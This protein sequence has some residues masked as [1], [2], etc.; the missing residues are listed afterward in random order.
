M[1]PP[2]TVP[3][4]LRSLLWPIAGL[5]LALLP[6]AW[7]TGPALAPPANAVPAKSAG[8]TDAEPQGLLRLGETLTKRGDYA[9]AEIAYWQILHR[10]D[11]SL[12]Q[13]KT[14]LLGLAHAHRRANE[15][16][17]AV[18]IY[19]KYLK[20]YPE[21]VRVPD[22]LLDLGRTLR[23]MGVYKMAISCFYSVIN[24]TLKFPTTGFEHYQLLAK[25]AQFEIAQTHFE[26]GEYADAG[27]YYSRVRLLEL[28]P[29]D[30]ARA[31]FMAAFA[32]Q[33]AGDLDTAVATLKAYLEAW[34]TDKNAPEARYLL[35]TTLRQLKRPQES[36]AVTL[37]LLRAE[38]T[39][40]AA[41]PQRWSYWQRR[42]GNQV[43]NEFFQNGDTF[44]ALAIYRGLNALSD[45]PA[46]KLP[47]TY[48]IALC[49]ERLRQLD[50]ARQAYQ[51][52]VD[53]GNPPTGQT[54]TAEAADLASMAAWRLAHLD[55]RDQAE[56]KIS[57]LF[58]MADSPPPPSLKAPL[59]PHSS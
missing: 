25:T 28:A 56:H 51:K 47:V 36:L 7:A 52:L 14:A 26:A 17:K 31:H 4:H 38:H 50:Q 10:S 46:W 15:M 54:A 33:L 27:K 13:T 30:R 39:R 12:L 43:A 58:P 9:T 34:P 41:D 53:A 21:D 32:E 5:A 37:D 24:S 40:V 44:N 23:D 18:A 22:C 8:A 11:V 1:N 49:Y 20:E 29:E 19:E 16:T 45:N 42:T 59:P 35:A 57:D 2:P 55:W 6:Q 3:R 48:Q